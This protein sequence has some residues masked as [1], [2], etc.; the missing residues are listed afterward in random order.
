M[1]IEEKSLLFLLK[2]PVSS[3]RSMAQTQAFLQAPGRAFVAMREADR[4]RLSEQSARPLYTL[5]AV[6][7]FRQMELS[8]IIMAWREGSSIQETLV[9]VSNEKLE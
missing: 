5:A 3:L 1:R 4:Q 9:V 7:R 2:R 6:R 8:D